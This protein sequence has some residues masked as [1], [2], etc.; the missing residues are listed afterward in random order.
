MTVRD[1]AFVLVIII[2]DN[3]NLF[4]M[5]PFCRPIEAL[6]HFSLYP[7]SDSSRTILATRFGPF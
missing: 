7:S 3:E 5:S 4:A 1:T 2:T 6:A